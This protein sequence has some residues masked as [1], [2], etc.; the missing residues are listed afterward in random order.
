MK[1]MKGSVKV[2]STPGKGSEFAITLPVTHNAEIE[3]VVAGNGNPLQTENS[4]LKYTPGD[5]IS[6]QPRY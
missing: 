4:N 2:K 3:E 5:G 1:L 6:N